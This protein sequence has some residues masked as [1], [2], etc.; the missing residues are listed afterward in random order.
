MQDPLLSGGTRRQ[1][2]E[3]QT[4][5]GVE[6]AGLELSAMGSLG[7]MAKPLASS[8]PTLG[9]LMISSGLIALNTLMTPQLLS[10]T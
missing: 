7:A 4:W 3:D 9:T 8:L 1:W 5:E 2:K 10:L 6:W